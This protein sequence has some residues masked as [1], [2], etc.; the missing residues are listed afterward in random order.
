MSARV[1]SNGYLNFT[2]ELI[3]GSMARAAS[4]AHIALSEA[5]K[6]LTYDKRRP[7]QSDDG[8]NPTWVDVLNQAELKT[9]EHLDS[10]FEEMFHVGHRAATI[11]GRIHPIIHRAIWDKRRKSKVHISSTPAKYSYIRAAWHSDAP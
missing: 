3:V 2:L 5:E 1:P 6:L 8:V 4:S 9:L 10:F 7:K 11:H